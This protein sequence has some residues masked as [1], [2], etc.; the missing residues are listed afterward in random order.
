MRRF[1]GTMLVLLG[2]AVIGCSKPY[3]KPLSSG[4]DP[5]EMRERYGNV[6]N[7]P[8]PETK[9][10]PIPVSA[11]K[12]EISG[13]NSRIDFVGTKPAGKHDGGFAKFTGTIKTDAAGKELGGMDVTIDMKSVWTDT[14]QLTQHLQSP[15]FFDVNE[16]PKATFTSTKIEPAKEGDA[17]HTITGDL[18]LR[19]TT[20]AITFPAT[21]KMADDGFSL[22]ATF[23]I[24]RQDYKVSFNKQPVDDDV[25]I[26]VQVGVVKK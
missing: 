17:T 23:K 22:K 6:G 16:H 8:R 20:K 24:N 5:T 10:Q 21:I 18:T 11:G 4:F 25:T 26:T 2:L 13:E 12:V 15:D 9:D 14:G 19:G 7:M 3:D 1:R